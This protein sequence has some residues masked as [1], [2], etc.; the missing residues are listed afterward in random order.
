MAG[1]SWWYN[2]NTGMALAQLGVPAAKMPPDAR[3]GYYSW[4]K[5]EGLTP[6]EAAIAITADI[7][8]IWYPMEDTNELI[9]SWA[10]SKKV[11]FDKP[12]VAEAM[13]KMNIGYR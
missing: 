5:S 9:G 13:R 10:R 3:L 6:V 2:V 4:A 11:N 12:L 7:F 8:G 1:V